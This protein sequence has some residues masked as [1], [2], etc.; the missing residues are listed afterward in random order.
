MTSLGYI[1]F[2]LELIMARPYPMHL[3]S[4]R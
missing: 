4:H 3:M 2:Y 1:Q